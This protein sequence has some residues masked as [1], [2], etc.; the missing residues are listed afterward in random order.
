MINLQN[1]TIVLHNK[2]HGIV[3]FSVWWVVDGLGLFTD[4]KEALETGRPMQP[5]PVAVASDGVYEVLPP[6]L[7]HGPQG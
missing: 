1:R 3:S 2:P 7:N 6:E 4:M 5:V